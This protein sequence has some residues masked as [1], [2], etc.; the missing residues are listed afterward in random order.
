MRHIISVLV[1]NEAGAL[2]RVA[3]LF[4]VRAYN[5]DSLTVAPTEDS[6]LSRMTV[7]TSGN[8]TAIEQIIKQLQKLVDVVMVE[9]L[10]SGAHIARE[11]LLLKVFVDTE[12]QKASVK[13]IVDIFKARVLDVT[14]STYT[15]EMTGGVSKSDAFLEALKDWNVAEVVRSGI[16]GIGRG[17]ETLNLDA[18]SDI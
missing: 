15:I 3:G 16:I 1:E 12:E 4:S 8:D 5:I 14:E 2:S 10:T 9:D 17:R 11:I 18:A 7:V 6:S 13:R